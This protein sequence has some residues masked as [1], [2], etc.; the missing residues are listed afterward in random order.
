M[1]VPSYREEL[2]SQIPAAHLL[3]NLGYEYPYLP[4]RYCVI[5]Q[6]NCGFTQTLL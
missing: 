1:A 5:A 2:I 6:R 3:V 4:R